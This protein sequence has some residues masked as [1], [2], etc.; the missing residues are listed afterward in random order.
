MSAVLKTRDYTGFSVGAVNGVDSLVD[1]SGAWAIVS[2]TPRYLQSSGTTND[3]TGFLV[4]AAGESALSC[5]GYSRFTYT[6]NTQE[7]ILRGVNLGGGTESGIALRLNENGILGFYPMS[8]GVNST[9]AIDRQFGGTAALSAGEYLL[10]WAIKDA[11]DSSHVDLF[12]QLSSYTAPA[13]ILAR[14]GKTAYTAAGITDQGAGFTA[15]HRN[16]SAEKI[17]VDSWWTYTGVISGTG[18]GGGASLG[19]ITATLLPS[20]FVALASP[21]WL[22]ETRNGQTT[23]TFSVGWYG[24]TPPFAIETGIGSSLGQAVSAMS[25]TSQGSFAATPAAITVTGLTAGTQQAVGLRITD[26]LGVVQDTRHVST[27][28]L[29]TKQMALFLWDSYASHTFNQDGSGSYTLT[30]NLLGSSGGFL[31]AAGE[32]AIAASGFVAANLVQ[33]INHKLGHRDVGNCDF[34]C[35]V[36]G[37]AGYQSSHYVPVYGQS[38]TALVVDASDNTV[39]SSA[40]AAFTTAIADTNYQYISIRGGTGWTPGVYQVQSRAGSKWRLDRSPAAVGTTGGTWGS[41]SNTNGSVYLAIGI[42]NYQKLAISEAYT[43]THRVVYPIGINDAL[44]GVAAATFATNVTATVNEALLLLGPGSLVYLLDPC[45]YDCSRGLGNLNGATAFPLLLDQATGYPAQYAAIAAANPSRVKHVSWS[46]DE[47]ARAG[48]AAVP[49]ASSGFSADGI[50]LTG[51]GVVELAN[52]IARPLATS[53][54]LISP[55]GGIRQA[56]LNGGF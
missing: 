51:P 19:A 4:G 2:A 43:G 34:Q 35:F 14:I 52:A 45:W 30:E 54:G 53:M 17:S 27:A 10:Q 6:G 41:I 31:T 22:V 5:G 21:P 8:G 23:R 55:S 33:Q 40:E 56:S 7:I 1:A 37:V 48:G 3:Q 11:G 20:P 44:N 36:S 38:G 50:H 42:Y 28:R 26:A 32:P 46:T 9:T 29:N 49:A 15:R 13:T 18:A 12:A 39:V 16:G 24:G 47:L 25:R